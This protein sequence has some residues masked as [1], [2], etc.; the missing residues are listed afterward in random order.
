MMVE[1]NNYEY[2]SVSLDPRSA[3]CIFTGQFGLPDKWD[4][5]SALNTTAMKW[6]VEG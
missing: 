3:S 6:L 4:F 2:F 5:T 1:N